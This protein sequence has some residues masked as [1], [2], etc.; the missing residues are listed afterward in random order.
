MDELL[1]SIPM[2]GN[3]K[4][5]A[6]PTPEE[7]NYWKARANRIFYIDYEV[8]ETYMLIELSKTIIQMNIEE[9]TIPVD[10]LKPIYLFI[11]SYGG[12]LEQANY[13]C[14]LVQSSRIPIITVAMGVAMSAGFLILLAGHKRYAFK[15]SQAL[16][17]TGSA[18]FQG[19]AEQIEEAQKNYKKL[20]E[21]MKRYILE[22]TE[23]DEKIFNKNKSKDWYLTSDE[24]VNYRVVDKLIENFED[25]L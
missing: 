18:G 6:L 25:I 12:D 21:G 22:R 10:Q 9:S 20:I 15:H 24:L 3:L 7:Y 4:D 1:L 16:V 23:I 13:F 5:S 11:H 19:T 14:D 17:H 2:V 8:D